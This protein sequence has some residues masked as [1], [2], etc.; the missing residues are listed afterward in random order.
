MA[1]RQTQ[2]IT[3]GATAAEGKLGAQEG[4][5]V[6]RSVLVFVIFNA[7]TS[8]GSVLVE[9]AHDKNYAGTWALLATVTWAAASKAHQVYIPGPQIAIRVRVVSVT[10]GTVDSF[11]VVQ[12]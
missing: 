2:V 3:A 6:A 1:R 7:G 10:G 8:A 12:D 4:L 5:L 9:A 11:V